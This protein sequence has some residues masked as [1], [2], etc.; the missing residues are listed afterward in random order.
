MLILVPLSYLARS[1]RSVTRAPGERTQMLGLGWV[2]W[3]NGSKRWVLERVVHL[4]RWRSWRMRRGHRTPCCPG[5]WKRRRA[6]GR[7]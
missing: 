4:F 3:L 2:G 5:G 6:C 7:D 1:V